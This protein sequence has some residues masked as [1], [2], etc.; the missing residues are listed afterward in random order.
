MLRS[1]EVAKRLGLHPLTVRRWVKEGKIAAVQLGREARIPITEVERLLGEQRAGTLILYG[2]VSG[3]D[4]PEDLQRQVQQ[5]EQW[6]LVA[7]TGQKTLTDIGSGLN[8]ERKSLQKLLALVQDY[9]VAE[10]VVTFADRLTRFGLSYLRSLFSGYGVTLTVLSPDEDKTPEQELTEDLLA[11][12]ASFAG[13]LYGLRS[14]KKAALVAC[15]KQVLAGADKHEQEWLMAKTQTLSFPIRL[16]DA[17]QAEALRL[18][19]ASRSA[20]NQIIFDL[21]PQL[22]R[23]ASN[24]TGPAWKH[25]ERHLLHRSGHGNRQ[26]RNEMEQAGRILRAQAT[27]KQVF[28]SVV[29]LLTDELIRPADEKRPARKDHR[30]ITEQVRALRA[31]MQDAGVL[32]GDDQHAGASLQSL[33]ANRGL[34]D[35]L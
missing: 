34:P 16:P 11:I 32:H 1:G 8:T 15:A 27:R 17:M 22:D 10:V 18:L 13:R 19:D 35:H 26:E 9:Q 30:A 25:V 7:R 29:P 2:R 6:A 4:Q 28:Q 31:Q 23:F 21:W 14:R 3:H 12:I 20:I 33:S 24:R 5:L